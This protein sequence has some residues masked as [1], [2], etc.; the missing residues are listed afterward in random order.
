MAPPSHTL[1]THHNE[2]V[3]AFARAE[4]TRG[5]MGV[6]LSIGEN[7]SFS[8]FRGERIEVAFFFWVVNFVGSAW[9]TVSSRPRVPSYVVGRTKGEE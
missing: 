4:S 6:M 2:Q 5:L 9:F 1:Y 7:W 8:E 3:T